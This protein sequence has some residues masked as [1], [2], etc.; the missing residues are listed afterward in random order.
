MGTTIENFVYF[1]ENIVLDKNQFEFT[2]NSRIR[3][4]CIADRK[5]D[6][7]FLDEIQFEGSTSSLVSITQQPSVA[8]SMSPTLASSSFSSISPTFSPTKSPTV[9][10]TTLFSCGN[11]GAPNCAECPQAWCNGECSWIDNQCQPLSLARKNELARF[12]DQAT[13]G[14]TKADLQVLDNSLPTDVAI[15]KWVDTQIN[16]VEIT[17]HRAWFRKYAIH[18]FPQATEVMRPRNVCEI[19]NKWRKYAFSSNDKDKEVLLQRKKQK[20]TI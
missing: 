19:N 9:S 5:G 10:P 18:H 13:F 7:I 14:V 17:S 6:K 16:N 4:R 15:A 1:E 20:A 8:T 12:L 11:H 2:P 3:F